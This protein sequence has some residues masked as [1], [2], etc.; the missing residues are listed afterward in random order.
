MVPSGEMWPVVKCVLTVSHPSQI[1]SILCLYKKTNMSTMLHT[2]TE[3]FWMKSDACATKSRKKA[4]IPKSQKVQ[5][6]ESVQNRD[7]YLY[8]WDCGQ[9]SRQS[10]PQVGAPSRRPS[11]QTRQSAEGYVRTAQSGTQRWRSAT[12]GH[13]VRH[14]PAVITVVALREAV[15][16]VLF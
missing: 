9:P 16:R 7:G 1:C 2:V 4:Y 14:T 3:M 5:L 13:P 11:T 6:W 10:K 12:Y 8:S 15:R